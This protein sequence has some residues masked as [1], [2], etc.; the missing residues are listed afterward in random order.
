MSTTEIAVYWGAIVM[1]VIATVMIFAGLVWKKQSWVDRASRVAFIGLIAQCVAV[2]LRW[3][4]AGHFPYIEDYENILVGSTVM[5]A[6]YLLIVWRN[7]SLSLVGAVVLPVVLVTMGY[8]L[9]QATPP[10]PVTPPYQSFWLAVHVTFAWITYAAYSTVAG[11]AL[12]LIL[13]VRAEKLGKESS[14]VPS[15]VPPSDQI[16]DISLKIVAFG[17]LNNAVMIASGAIWAHRLWGAYWSWDPVET[18]S[19]LTWLAYG[20][21]MHARLTLGWRGVRL[22][23]LAL[24]ALFGVL[25]TFWGV[26]LAPTSYH[27]FRDIGSGMIDSSR[28]M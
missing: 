11:L 14:G 24:F 28:P 26:Q 5:I 2:G 25:M 7:R 16:D 20:F 19:L 22:A 27:L 1:F 23:A 17:F 9:T 12:A 15:W 3:G 8:G 6:A 18:W 4:A 13:R 10:G 21:Y